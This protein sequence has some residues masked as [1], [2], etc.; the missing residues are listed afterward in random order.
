MSSHPNDSEHPL[1]SVTLR[2]TSAVLIGCCLAI[3]AS[4]K[5]EPIASASAA[6]KAAPLRDGSIDLGRFAVP[7]FLAGSAEDVT[8]V[9]SFNIVMLV[10]PAQAEE[11]KQYVPAY[12]DVV[13]ATSFAYAG[14]LARNRL[15][16]S[17]EKL[18]MLILDRIKASAVTLIPQF[19]MLA[20]FQEIDSGSRAAPPG[21]P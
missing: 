17:P 18:G 20:N 4:S 14:F 9:L 11:F 21:P 2:L 6:E 10:P 16:A 7:L 3:V 15:P 1:G 12:R 19:V 8:G 13:I 5:W